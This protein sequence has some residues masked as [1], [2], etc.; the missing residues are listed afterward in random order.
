[1]NRGKNG[2]PISR[3]ERWGFIIFGSIRSI[4]IKLF[5][6][7][8][9]D[10][11]EDWFIVAESADEAT[12]FHEYQEGYDP[13]DARAEMILEIPDG[14]K[15]DL[16]WPSEDVLRSCGAKILSGESPR[17]VEIG[18][19]RFCEGLMESTIRTLDDG[20]FDA[21]AKGRPNKSEKTMVH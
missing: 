21:L 15:V 2:N 11:A 10:H 4:S 1:M 9:E 6:V 8:T 13:G 17:I 7:T 12:A 3:T 14:I 19:R 20:I 18:N 16:G 5:W